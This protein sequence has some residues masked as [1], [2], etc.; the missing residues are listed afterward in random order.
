ML[1]FF[2]LLTR[3]QP[4]IVFRYDLQTEPLS[5][6]VSHD[7]GEVNLRDLPRERIS[8]PEQLLLNILVHQPPKNGR[9]LIGKEYRERVL[10]FLRD[11]LPQQVSLPPENPRL[12]LNYLI[13]PARQSC[14][15]WVDFAGTRCSALRDVP[16]D[17][18]SAAERVFIN[19]LAGV[20]LNNG[21]F[22]VGQHLLARLYYLLAKLPSVSIP[23][24]NPLKIQN[25]TPSL[26][27]V[28]QAKNGRYKFLLKINDVILTEQN[29]K[30]FGERN[31]VLLHGG[32]IYA[33]DHFSALLLEY[34]LPSDIFLEKN[35]VPRFAADCL[36]ILQAKGLPL[37]LPAELAAV[38]KSVIGS[39]AAPLLEVVAQQDDRL[40]LKIKY[41][42]GLPV[43]PEYRADNNADFYEVRLQGRKHF[44][45]RDKKSEDWLHNYLCDLHFTPQG[46]SYLVSHDDFVDFITYEFPAL[47][48]N[49]GLK[50]AGANL[51]QYVYADQSFAVDLNFRQ[52][53]GIDW[54]E[55]TPLYKIKGDIFTHEQIRGLINARKEY[56]RLPDGSLVKVPQE[57]FTYLQ[58][59]LSGRG[60]PA[61][62]GKYQVKKHD[63]YYL[64]SGVRERMCAQVDDSLQT[65]LHKL[66]DFSG[67]PAVDLPQDIQGEPR[68]YQ[69]Q[70]YHWLHFLHDNN[71]H[72]ILA[73]DMGLGKT[74]QVLLL[75]LRLQQDGRL[76]NPALIVAP[77]SVVYNWVNEIKKF[78]P[79]LRVL[80]L[81][82]SRSRVLKVKEASG[83]DILITSY[84]M[85]RNDLAHYSQKE[86]D[87][88]VLDEA[89]YI[90]NP[91]TGIAKAVKCLQTRWRLAL[92][93]TPVENHLSELWSIFDYLM[94]GFLSTLSFFKA[95][96]GSDHERLRQK[97]HPF[98]LR[99]AKEEVLTELP[100]KNE[101]E[102]FCELL[103][104]QEALYVHILQSQRQKLM[105]ALR[106]SDIGK[107]QLNILAC[108]LK[109]RQAC[110]H[111]AL[112]K[113]EATIT[114]S[115]K[116]NQFKELIAEILE[117]GS[118]VIVFSQFVEM[119]SIMR[120]YLDGAQ[121]PY[122]YLDG[123]TRNRQAVIDNFN[124][125]RRLPI[126]LCSLKAGGIGINLTSANYVIIYDPWWNPAVE[127]QAMDRVYRI[128]QT[129]EVFVYKLIT[130]GTV[131][132]KILALQNKKKSLIDAVI[133]SDLATEKKI[134]KEELEDLLSY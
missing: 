106:T 89:Q 94:P 30:L 35:E 118:K 63:L 50:L 60:K 34:Y 120:Q 55:F 72:G 114:E 27:G 122:A 104:E 113:G 20:P 132:E 97:I 93:G 111:P 29:A 76:Q 51:N 85:L 81:S 28:F 86:F 112:L 10:F 62:N 102:S 131:E 21:S 43:L 107:L 15:V 130:K 47:Q 127:Q 69:R 84:A 4:N 65:L 56:V 98:I 74:L 134:T 124:V 119:L 53:S 25:R 101:I 1:D 11:I 133:T 19:F 49:I 103:P 22:F 66:A 33:L 5:I 12:Q 92:T 36:P 115:A 18:L 48:T 42:Y 39:P 7:A 73:D 6:A 91:K 32:E 59:Y 82:G 38:H 13:E 96:Y 2:L 117:N 61:A 99:R 40:E 41:D 24:G 9:S 128:G 95:M 26:Q 52:T 87:Y 46:G 67:I 70:G 90:K 116:F 123:A 16:K 80:V 108:L 54:F 64:Y 31:F 14:R 23:S 68:A 3:I 77:T 17:Q 71:F 45:K 75:L 125:E 109:L 100:P 88:L 58:G 8:I 37:L 44:L 121:I 78:T 79:S 126:F 105:S 57:E 110:C 129:K 83:Y